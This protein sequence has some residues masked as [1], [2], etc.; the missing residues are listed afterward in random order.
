M[1]QFGN[2]M[3]EL[4]GATFK[5]IS[6]E[7]FLLKKKKYVNLKQWMECFT[8]PHVYAEKSPQKTTEKKSAL[9]T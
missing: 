1:I 9:Q 7:M 8:N 2:K 5:Y 6:K 4:R 3:Y